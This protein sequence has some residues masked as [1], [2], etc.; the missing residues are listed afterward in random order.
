MKK[1][2]PLIHNKILF[3]VSI[4]ILL[5]QLISQ[6]KLSAQTVTTFAGSGSVGSTNATGT[7]ASFN[8]PYSIAIDG[9]GNLYIADASNNKIRKITPA[10][11]VTTLA[12]AGTAGSTDATGT[13]ASFNFPTGVA[14]DG[15][16]N[17]YVADQANNKI[18]KITSGGV[19]TTFAGSGTMASTDGTGTGAS[20]YYP[21]DIAIDGSGNLFVLESA[22]NTI[23]KI[24]PGG[25]VTTFAGSSTA[26]STDATGTAARFNNPECI[27]IDGS[28]NLYVTDYGNNKIRKITS[29]GV[30]TTLAGSGTSA[31]VDGTGTGASFNAAYGVE[32]DASGN[33]YIG[34]YYGE[35]IRKI[36]SAG[37]VTT[38]AGTGTNGSA[39]GVGT[40]ASFYAPIGL[41]FDGVGNLFIADADN[42]KIRKMTLPCALGIPATPTASVTAQPTVAV[43]TGTIVVTAPTG[44]FEYSVDGVNYQA[45]TSFSSLAP[46][47]TY[48]V[49]TRNSAD[50]NCISASTNLLVN[51]VPGT[52]SALETGQSIVTGNLYPNPAKNEIYIRLPEAMKNQS[53]YKVTI[54]DGSGKATETVGYEATADVLRLTITSLEKG[55]YQVFISAGN[56]TIKEKLVVE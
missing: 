37:V 12:G 48:P 31:T 22:N 24:T 35:T 53:Q 55:L 10:G 39:D 20:F 45:G 9:S 6:T 32:V 54:Y 8:S 40:A 52:V 30:V 47:A 51:A 5:S 33:V 49:T 11:V 34:E 29:A 14:V 50:H 26:G 21:S 44:S 18:R 28:G 23:R 43:P 41:V 3:A 4:T 15:S 7:A 19:V 16:G 56:N 2:L 13:A 42:N 36:T 46:N 17:I 1:N 27:A 25:V 38:L